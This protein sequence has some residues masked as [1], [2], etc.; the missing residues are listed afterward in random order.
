MTFDEWIERRLLNI[1]ADLDKQISKAKQVM[2]DARARLSR[3]SR[4]LSNEYL[5]LMSRRFNPCEKIG[6][7]KD[8]PDTVRKIEELIAKKEQLEAKRDNATDLDRELLLAEIEQIDDQLAE[9]RKKYI[10]C[11][12]A[13][14]ELMKEY[15]E[16]NKEVA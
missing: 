14:D 6:L 13:R 9:A 5:K 8:Y 12:S 4:P 15:K 1:S 11:K 10:R 7:L 3:T 2:D 16:Y